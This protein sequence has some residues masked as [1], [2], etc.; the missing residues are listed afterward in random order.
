MNFPGNSVFVFI[1]SQ[2]TDLNAFG[3]GKILSGFAQGFRFAKYR[4]VPIAQVNFIG[5]H[6][7]KC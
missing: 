5:K 4:Y 6:G 7:R 2:H 1:T 3:F